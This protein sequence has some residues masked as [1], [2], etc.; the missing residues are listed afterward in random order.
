MIG[1]ILGIYKKNKW[2]VLA[3]AAMVLLASILVF[4]TKALS[5]WFGVDRKVTFNGDTWD[6]ND[7]FNKGWK[8]NGD[9]VTF[10]VDLQD[11]YENK[12]KEPPAE[13]VDRPFT[14]KAA[15]QGDGISVPEPVKVG[16]EAGFKGQYQVTIPFNKEG[17]LDIHISIDGN[18]GWD[19]RQS[20]GSFSITRDTTAPA[21]ELSGIE[22][23][24][25]STGDVGIKVKV[26]ETHFQTSQVDVSVTKDGK[27]AGQLDW[28]NRGETTEKT[29]Y[30][31]KDGE[32]KLSVSAV[33]ELG[34]ASGTKTISFA[35]RTKGPVLSISDLEGNKPLDEMTKTKKIGI[36]VESGISI[37]FAY[38][39]ITKDGTAL[40]KQNLTVDGKSASL[41]YPV[42][43]GNYKL[44]VYVAEKHA[45]GK[46]HQLPA[47]TFTVD[48]S[49]PQVSVEGVKDKEKY[50]SAKSI[51]IAAQD[52]HFSGGEVTVTRTG[53][54]GKET[55]QTYQL[56]REGKAALRAERDGLY[57]ISIQAADK[58]GNQTQK[59]ISFTIDG[60]K[61]E[62][63]LSEDVD[64]KYFNENKTLKV[65]VQDF[66]LVE[67]PVLKVKKDGKEYL[68]EELDLS[69]FHY[70]KI[71][72]FKEDGVYELQLSTTDAFG[73]ES[74]LEPVTFTIDQTKPELGIE[75]V[76]N[77]QI[78]NSDLTIGITAADKNFVLE[79]TKL[80]VTRNGATYLDA[81]GKDGVQKHKFDQDGEYV[82]YLESADKAG[83]KA[84][85]E[86]AFTLDKTKPGLSITGVENKEIA[87]KKDNVILAVEDLTLDLKRTAVEVT[88]DGKVYDLGKLEWETTRTSS[89]L[90]KGAAQLSFEQEGTYEI[91]FSSADAKE[92][93]AESVKVAFTI[94]HTPP[95]L[96]IKNV[97]N[98]GLYKEPKKVEIS[99]KDL[100][101]VIENTKLYVTCNGK[102]YLKA[103]G[104]EAVKSHL[105]QDD[106]EYVIYLES[107]DQPGNKAQHQPV[108]FTIDQTA[109]KLSITGVENGEAAQK[110][111][112]VILAVEDLTLDMK[113]TAVKVTRDGKEF[114]P[115][116]LKWNRTKTEAGLKKAAAELSFDQEGSYEI[117]FSSADSKENAAQTLKVAFDIDQTAPAL[118]VK[119][120]EN[121][122]LYKE[123]RTI[124]ISVTDLHPAIESTRLYITRN[125][126]E[127]LKENGEEAVASHL[128]DE[129]GEYVL[130]LESTDGPG[131]K[132]ELE[133]ISFT[134][135]QT[136]PK[137]KITGVDEE[138]HAK[139][140]EGIVLTAEDLTLDLKETVVAVTR[141]GKA[142]DLGKLDWKVTKSD[143]NIRTAEVKLSFKKE[144]DYVIQFSSTDAAKNSADH[145][146]KAFTID[147]TAPKISLGGIA[148]GAFAQ[149]GKTVTIK[150]D[151]H[152][153]AY[154]KVKIRATRNH[155]E[156]DLGNWENTGE[157]SKLSHVFNSD[158]D[159][160]ITV[161]AEDKAGNAAEAKTLSFTVDNVKPA[162]D[163]SG[164]SKDAYYKNGKNVSIQIKEHNF[165]NNDVSISVTRQIEVNGKKA[166]YFIGEWNN[167]SEVSSLSHHF[168]QDGEYEIIVKATDAAGNKAETKTAH[169]T[170]DQAAPGLSIT[171]VESGEDYPVSKPVTMEATDRNIDLANTKISVTRDGK[172][173]NIGRP[174]LAN[175]ITAAKS[176]TFNEEGRYVI[177]FKAT[178]KAGN[179][180]THDQIDFIIDKTTPV[181]KIDGVEDGS[182]N[183]QSKY[184]TLSV[185]E[186]NYK[187]NNVSV[188]ATKDG[189]PF[190]MGA[191][192]NTG[193]VSK[194]GY[195]FS[196]DGLYTLNISAEDK[197][198]N[199]PAS[200]KT[201]F[202]IDTVKPA[203][204]IF[205][206]E[207]N[208][209]YNVTKP[210]SVSITDVNLD[211][212]RIKVTRNGMS[213]SPGGFAV[214]GNKASLSHS[215]GQEGEYHVTVDATD[216][217]GNSFSREITFTIDKTK[218][219][220]TPK[221]N[222]ETIKDGAY[223]NKVF[224]PAF[225]LDQSEDSIVSVSLNGKNMGTNIPMASKEMKYSY[226]VL[227]RDKAGNEA[228]LEISFTLDTT[229]PQLNVT[230][231]LDGY[232]KDNIAPRV[233]YS[234]IHLDSGKTS[235]TLNGQPYV[236]GTRLEKE[237]DYVLKA[238]I[239]D[240]AGNVSSRTI[241]FT[242]DKTSPVIKFK[243]PISNKYFNEDLIPELLI[244][245]LNA[246][247]I[248]AMMLD[249]KSYELG[250]PIKEEGKH[251][252]FFEVKDKA[253]NI[254]QM[255]VEF[256]IDKSA[257]KVIFEGVKKAAK[258]RD[259]VNISITLDNPQDTIKD[260]TINGE[261][262]DGEVVEENGQKVIKTTLS[263]IN[264]YEIKVTAYDEAGNETE[265]VLPF[266]IVE[267]GALVK[268]Y[269]NKPLF[270]GTIAGLL[271]IVTAAGFM[272]ARS[273]KEEQ[274]EE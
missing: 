21:V 267:K 165:K 162:I 157:T 31:N 47:Y 244:E 254:K 265:T 153:F 98:N 236:N 123:A 149:K 45:Q 118:E 201:T 127:F 7:R 23:G 73:R 212:N 44:T 185:D 145:A 160:E 190:S 114:D 101:N 111:E 14:I 62:V 272:V 18:N 232:F 245:D 226:K 164:V 270:A 46:T 262:F 69:F 102:E 252:L 202:T 171:G 40:P 115:G 271:G 208:A 92:N 136:K 82:I 169:F 235:V 28:Q 192:K 38:V 29:Y 243:E 121:N 194:L 72:T 230:G 34:N 81:S 112:H 108:A 113:R 189:S 74:G 238:L 32:Y 198:G 70:Q 218:P 269:E 48:H 85:K 125:G 260:V 57:E 76:E 24:A 137:L 247:D 268:L 200:R 143:D 95:V 1:T 182:F 5:S 188:T 4:D 19:A 214:S 248:I 10:V 233:T 50:E 2:I 154:N 43:E 242:I 205:G 213:Y 3:S 79:N 83:N 64:G 110:K 66:T 219:V 151:E 249:G 148:Q 223:I 77:S 117:S 20:S 152:N 146:S 231:V 9:S 180:T 86:V 170:I 60:D 258:Y 141:D 210:V 250:D 49:A 240:L 264:K 163:I 89:G 253:G 54:N 61:P 191:W 241:V 58:A 183:P 150:V 104:K 68:N 16:G 134:I 119:N 274:P 116:K 273:R 217:A 158:G 99:V 168:G 239:T 186:L 135:D 195:N 203:I 80:Y 67:K 106:G 181:V 131:N 207:N 237:Q 209:Y 147:H 228:T 78:Y 184:V 246:Y 172:A 215:F 159:Y 88:R 251:V 42:E 122:G 140:K 84:T 27:S 263:D 167:A 15:Y 206:V 75:N 13:P 100:H 51:E 221:M 155:E 176:F 25:L 216:K 187:T 97:E 173:Y 22:N 17:R 59:A 255:S 96:E 211:I 179:S 261:L 144:G 11:D 234:D 229:K 26:A 33:D 220:I 107:T 53:Y 133:P 39:E 30:F 12:F 225:A 178:D 65:S 266:E 91:T 199:G 63:K 196:R 129:D 41:S 109:P 177:S 197:A 124:E 52:L 128:I 71:L 257:P 138:E 227:A 161:S 139:S 142:Y 87:Q 36:S 56:N 166:A 105:F 224:T 204:E 103:N 256:I 156:Y 55:P 132:R 90:K 259:P 94:D 222:G 35:I 6:M 37:G 8:T 126:K 93:A 130:Y 120:V 175:A 174:A 193:K